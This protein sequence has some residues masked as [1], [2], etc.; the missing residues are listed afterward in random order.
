[1]SSI[2]VLWDAGSTLSFITFKKARELNLH[3]PKELQLQVVKVGGTIENVRSAKFKFVLVDKNGVQVNVTM[4]GI[5]KIST[6]ILAINTNDVKELFPRELADNI[7]RPDQG[8]IDCLIGFE[9]A[10]FHPVK[11]ASNGHLLLLSNRFG[12]LIGGTHASIKEGA[13]K[14]IF[15]A[16]IHFASLKKNDFFSIES[17]GVEVNPRCGSCRCGECHPGG[18]NMSLKEEREYKLIEERLVYSKKDKKW[19]AS[20]PWV[21]DPAN[22]PNNR[23]AALNT[24]KRINV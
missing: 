10:D 1:M 9:Y 11:K 24:L 16:A 18:K 12:N 5:D 19:E 2:N 8:E 22:L 6:D 21:K 15:H 20:L 17:L 14:V 13:K 7:D 4:L 3:S 23:A